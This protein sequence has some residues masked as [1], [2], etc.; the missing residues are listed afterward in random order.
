MDAVAKREIVALLL[1]EARSIQPKERTE[2]KQKDSLI[3]ATT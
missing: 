2:G 1:I 3:N